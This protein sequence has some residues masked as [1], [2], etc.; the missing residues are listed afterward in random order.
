[1]SPAAQAAILSQ[2]FQLSAASNRMALRW[3]GPPLAVDDNVSHGS[4]L[5]S[6]V[7]RGTVQLLPSG[8]LLTLMADHQTVGGYPRVMQVQ[9]T[10]L[11][12]LAQ[13]PPGTSIHW[14]LSSVEAATEALLLQQKQL[15]QLAAAVRFQLAATG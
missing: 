7:I 1:L 2:P 13:L 5:S 15:L 6:P 8:Q 14:Q 4:M 11:S 9:R 12:F 3:Q 10:H